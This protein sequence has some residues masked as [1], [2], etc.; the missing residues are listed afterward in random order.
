MKTNDHYASESKN[1]SMIL[2]KYGDEIEHF[3][4]NN[5]FPCVSTCF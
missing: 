3:F 5:I 2:N 1:K 4:E